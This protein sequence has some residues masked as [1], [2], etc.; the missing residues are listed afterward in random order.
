VGVALITL[1][2]DPDLVPDPSRPDRRAPHP[3]RHHGP[4]V[5]PAGA[6]VTGRCAGVAGRRAGAL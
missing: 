2:T 1:G 5:R 6:F 3:H 4:D